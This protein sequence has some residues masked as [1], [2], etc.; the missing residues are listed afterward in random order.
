MLQELSIRQFAIIDD[1]RI[2]FEDG[3]TIL[4]G[5]TGAG[6]SI[7]I[8]AVNLL[9]GSRASEK[10][11]RTGAASAEVEA[12]FR[13]EPAS[14]VAQSMENQGFSASEGLLIRR[15]ISRSGRHRV[16][17]NDRLST[18][19]VL[20]TL[21]RHMASISGQHAHQG[22]L[23]EDQQLLILD[24]I[25]G[26]LPLRKKV[27][28]AFHSLLPLIRQYH[29]LIQSKDRQQDQIQL[30]RFQQQEIQ[31]ARASIGEDAELE[32][33]IAR[34]KNAEM[35]NDVIRSSIDSL[36]TASGAVVER[37]MEVG[38]Q[39]AQASRIDADLEPPSQAL[40]ESAY[41][42]E[43]VVA[44]L[45][46]YLG[47]IQV[48]ERRLETA[49]ERMDLLVRLKRKY[50]QTLEDVFTKLA[51]I[52]QEL[53][54]VE[55]LS[56][57]ISE[58]HK[59]LVA[60]QSQAITLC[61]QLAK[62]RQDAAQR[63]SQAAETEL[64]TLKMNQTRFQVCLSPVNSTPE[65]DPFLVSN[66]RLLTETGFETARFMIAPNVGE[67]LKPMS[68]IASGGELSRIVL[69]LKAILAQNDVVETIIFDEVDAG[70][71]GT[72]A[73]VVGKKLAK[74]SRFH[75]VVCITHLPQIARFG[76]HQFKIAKQIVDQRTATTIHLLTHDERINEIA[77]M[78]AGENVTKKTLAHASEMMAGAINT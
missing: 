69:A 29:K 67:A 4:S 53:T 45:R 38:K 65:V 63:L 39:L 28:E 54:Q 24:Q 13:V 64:A 7:I 62:K 27:H 5:E 68:D 43:D 48:D 26:L 17:I 32:Q 47:R 15:I 52:E 33:E 70:I 2:S 18:M 9:L 25:G 78:L 12:L 71:G 46:T 19:S 60:L 72:V 23:K 37:I 73:E 44:S 20:K 22:L 59:T 35:L 8:N 76:D 74:L 42:I 14:P 57:K 50:G 3:L 56:G 36:Y 31:A 1:I 55:N 75:Q 6:K 61:E 77:R 10:M 58:T 34:L 66:D 41:R 30:L 40:S 11:I 51:A 21:T 16:Y 49:E